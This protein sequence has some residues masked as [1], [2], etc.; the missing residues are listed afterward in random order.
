MKICRLCLTQLNSDNW[1]LS[2]SKINNQI[3]KS[4]SKI[5][6]KKW[7]ENN[8]GKM[9]EYSKKDY[10]KNREKKLKAKKIWDANNREH[11]SKRDKERRAKYRLQVI[12]HYGNKCNCCNESEYRFL[13]I[14]HVNND[15]NKH[16]AELK[17]RAQAHL[18]RTIIKENYP[19]KY[20]IL[21][22]NCNMGKAL[23]N[24]ICPHIKSVE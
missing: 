15:G 12:Q 10:Y 7:F 11:I 19:D 21:C 13:T 16:R 22:F 23:N 3:C 24:G 4:C 14:D 2:L 18:Y 20:Q 5:K 6:N 9:S 17:S 1:Y 8:P